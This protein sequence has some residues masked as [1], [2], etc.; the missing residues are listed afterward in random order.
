MS[1]HC[2]APIVDLDC[3]ALILGS[4]PGEESLRKQEYYAYPRNAF[5]QLISGTLH[6]LPYA[7]KCAYMLSRNIALWD[8]LL[9]AERKG[10]LDSNI[11]NEV[12]NDFSRFLRQYPNIQHIFF[13][14]GKAKSAFEKYF[15]DLYLDYE[16]AQLP[17]SSPA[18][19]LSFEEK[20][21]VWRQALTLFV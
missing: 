8:V 20:Q 1:K 9:S 21:V 10:S 15:T 17:S 16:C 4:M 3:T 6:E 19:T 18:Y 13:N 12:S 7:E 2:F 5:W 11:K 14:G